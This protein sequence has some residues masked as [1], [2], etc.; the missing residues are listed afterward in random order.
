MELFLRGRKLSILE[1]YFK[2]SKTKTKSNT[3]SHENSQQ[4]KTSTNGIKYLPYIDFKDF[5]KLNEEYTK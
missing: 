5:V 1:F 2:V 4:N 3:F